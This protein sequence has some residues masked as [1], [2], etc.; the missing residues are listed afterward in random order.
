MAYIMKKFGLCSHVAMPSHICSCSSMV[1][2]SHVVKP[3]Q[4]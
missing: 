3:S 4:C 2:P 1:M